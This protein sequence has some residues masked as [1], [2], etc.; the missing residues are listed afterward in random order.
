MTD[1]ERPECRKD[2]DGHDNNPRIGQ[3]G[4]KQNYKDNGLYVQGCIHERDISFLLDSGAT[5]SLISKATYE[6]CAEGFN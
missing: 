3:V 5:A 6:R 1:T 4:I 2:S